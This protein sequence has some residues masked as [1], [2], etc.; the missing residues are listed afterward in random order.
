MLTYW[1]ET[2]EK[3]HDI[4]GLIMIEFDHSR[5]DRH[6]VA[7]Y[8]S[9]F[10]QRSIIFIDF[11]APTRVA[12]FASDFTVQGRDFAFFSTT[13]RS[14]RLNLDG[15]IHFWYVFGRRPPNYFKIRRSAIQWMLASEKKS[16][17]Q[18]QLIS[19]FKRDLS[20]CC[21]R[22]GCEQEHV[23]SNEE[24]QV[25]IRFNETTLAN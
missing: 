10:S 8:T 11:R 24:E 4:S 21:H 5:S 23:C 9:V 16:P 19:G 3:D 6:L 7:K 25:G 14:G 1:L 15:G 22:H 2:L 13:W 12:G 20:L 18:Q 17:T